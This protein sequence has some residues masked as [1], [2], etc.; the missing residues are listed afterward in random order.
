V[1]TPCNHRASVHSR[2]PYIC[3][4]CVCVDAKQRDGRR[5]W[6]NWCGR[7]SWFQRL[8]IFLL[9]VTRLFYILRLPLISDGTLIYL[10]VI[11]YIASCAVRTLLTCVQFRLTIVVTSR[12]EKFVIVVT[13]QKRGVNGCIFHGN[14]A[15]ELLSVAAS[16]RL[17]CF[18][19]LGFDATLVRCCIWCSSVD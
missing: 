10:L 4:D 15:I 6:K 12:N 3:T 1:S 11:I 13:S 16:G 19:N 8:A 17:K 2:A 5:S 14:L 9:S 7:P 18:V